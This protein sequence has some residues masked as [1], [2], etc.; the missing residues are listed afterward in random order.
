MRKT[1]EKI[2]DRIYN[3]TLYLLESNNK[4]GGQNY[5]NRGDSFYTQKNIVDELSH[6]DLSGKIIYCNCDNP[7]MSNFYK[8]FK[9]NFNTLG[10][11]GL[12]ATYYDNN[13]KDVLF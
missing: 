10:L 11:K 13:P 4:I 9:N 6:Y 5:A 12:Y 2:I 8:F 1:I 3:N 7:T